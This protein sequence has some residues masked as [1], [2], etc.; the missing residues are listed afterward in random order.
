MVRELKI[1]EQLIGDNHPCFITFE[2][3]PTISNLSTALSLVEE[4]AKSGA[5]AIKFQIFNPDKLVKDKKQMFTYSILVN[6]ETGELKEV[7][8]PLYDIL[9]RRCLSKKE[10]QIVKNKADMLNLAFFSTIGFEE[11]L[12]FLKNMKCDSVKIAS[13]DV[14]HFP[15]LRL[16]AKSGMNVQLDTGNSDLNEIKD[17]V[18][19]LEKEGCKSIIIHQCPS[20]YPAKL[21]SICLRMIKTLKDNFP[22]Y[23]IAYS[24]HTP[25]ADMD[26]AAVSLG[27][28]LVEKTITLNR[29]TPSVEHLFS[30]EPKDMRGFIE[31]IRNLE[32]ALGSFNREITD[33]Q[34]A[35]RRLL[36]RSPYLTQNVSKCESIS[37]VGI[38]FRRPG[39]GM[40]PIE[41]EILKESN[42][43]FKSSFSEGNLL[44]VEMFDLN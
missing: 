32:T 24:D 16:A 39:V 11:D 26:I 44:K 41:W 8:E 14:N 7:S 42:A 31:R 18:A 38:E 15:L 28:N 29:M 37:N 3:G 20:G 17:A 21:P 27:A 30:L 40:S 34:K 36:R 22:N 19:V 5:D 6:R 9:S 13:S 1:G 12:E 33:K 35:D 23:P 43:K 4:A 10:W 25:E 2:A